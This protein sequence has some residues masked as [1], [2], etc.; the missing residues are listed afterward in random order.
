MLAKASGRN[1]CNSDEGESPEGGGQTSE[2]GRKDCV[3]PPESQGGE[4]GQGYGDGDA[5][6]TQLP[7]T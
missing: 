3:S 6:S 5:E 7:V 2:Q 1:G 4:D